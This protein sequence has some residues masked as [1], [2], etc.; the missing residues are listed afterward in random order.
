MMLACLGVKKKPIFKETYHHLYL[1]LKIQRGMLVDHQVSLQ[2]TQQ[3]SS[4]RA[5]TVPSPQ[6]TC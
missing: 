2:A 4:H 6:H 5:Q 1:D 3:A